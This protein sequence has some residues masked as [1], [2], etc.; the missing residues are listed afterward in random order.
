MKYKKYVILFLLLVIAYAS[1]RH[2]NVSL[3]LHSVKTTTI[4]QNPHK[5]ITIKNN[6]NIKKIINLVSDFNLKNN[7]LYNGKGCAYAIEIDRHYVEVLDDMIIIDGF[8]YTSKDNNFMELMFK[9]ITEIFLEES[10]NIG[11]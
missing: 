3:K 10:K 11:I 8:K 4:S 9:E 6:S 1:F 7:G 2:F 5:I